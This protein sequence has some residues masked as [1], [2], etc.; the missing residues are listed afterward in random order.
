MTLPVWPASLPR[1]PRADGYTRQARFAP[2]VTEMEDGPVL[3]RRRSRIKARKETLTLVMDGA[4]LA[5]FETFFD[6]V[7]RGGTLR[8]T[9]PT[10]N[11]D[12]TFTTRTV[13]LEGDR[14][15]VAPFGADHWQVP[16]NL[17][18]FS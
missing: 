2:A 8:F 17:T 5:A 1:E 9:M 4:Q 6:D 16:L 18:V 7:L 11:P 14:P 15:K 13:H 10:V 3:A 12:G